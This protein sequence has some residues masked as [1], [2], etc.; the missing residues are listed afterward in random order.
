MP[1]RDQPITRMLVMRKTSE[2]ECRLKLPSAHS[3]IRPARLHSG[4][5]SRSPLY[6]LNFPVL[7]ARADIKLMA[8]II[9]SI[10]TAYHLAIATIS[11]G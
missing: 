3:R 2:A 8:S 4:T 10:S 6:I 7:C 11:G 1:Y 5:N 9:G